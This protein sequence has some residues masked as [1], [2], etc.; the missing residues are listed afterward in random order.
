VARNPSPL[1]HLVALAA[2]TA[3]I[4][5]NRLLHTLF[6]RPS[7]DL[8]ATPVALPRPGSPFA[9]PSLSAYPMTSS[10]WEHKPQG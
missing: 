4:H 9:F 8:S 2:C 6:V 10:F 3:F 1:P 7:F 5:C